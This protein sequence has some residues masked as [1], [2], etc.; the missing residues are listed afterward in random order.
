MLKILGIVAGLLVLAIVGVVI[1]ASTKPDTFGV[2]RTTSINAA[3]EKI[4]PY[5]ND[6]R[7][8][9]EWSPWEKMDPGMARSY[10]GPDSG[11]GQFYS[12]DSKNAGAG[13]Q[14]IV[15]S[16]LSRVLIELNFTRPFKSENMAEFRM[17]PKG[18]ATEVT[19]S[20][21]GPAP[22]YAK[23]M[24]L[25]FN[26]DKEIGGAFAQGLADLKTVVEK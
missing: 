16:T 26:V 13:S 23:V 22:L 5:I 21:W 18:A 17:E 14:K 10:S 9:V 4:A 1:Y 12:W 8:A 25:F 11:V 19:W 6:L 24:H 7:R 3:P 2:S 20:M 15:E